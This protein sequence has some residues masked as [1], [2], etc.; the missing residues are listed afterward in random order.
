M[1]WNGTPKRSKSH[2]PL[3]HHEL[4]DSYGRRQ[5]Q[6]DVREH[7]GALNENH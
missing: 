5:E 2:V 4:L 1:S 3:E 7:H 6:P